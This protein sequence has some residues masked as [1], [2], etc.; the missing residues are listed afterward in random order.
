[1]E[2]AA[3]LHLPLRTYV[4][5]A[6]L[7]ARI[8]PPV[9]EVNAALARELSRVGGNLNQFLHAVH[10]GKTPEPPAVDLLQLQLLLAQV[11]RQL[12]GEAP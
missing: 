4:R 12:R 11:R 9:P 1:M 5:R 8:P 3:Q 6:A 10:A 7:G 2:L